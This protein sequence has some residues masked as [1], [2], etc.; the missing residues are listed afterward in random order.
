MRAY[1]RFKLGCVSKG[2]DECNTY[3]LLEHERGV[4]VQLR[5]VVVNIP[6]ELLDALLL[7]G[8]L[9]VVVG[10]LFDEPGHRLGCD[11]ER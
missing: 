10:F 3:L 11:G 6:L 8:L 9:L 5:I 7:V 1:L 4:A 2:G